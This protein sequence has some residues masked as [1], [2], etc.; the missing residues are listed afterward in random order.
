[1]KIESTIEDAEVSSRHTNNA[2]KLMTIFMQNV[3]G[4]V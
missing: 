3:L 1:M 4:L 2:G